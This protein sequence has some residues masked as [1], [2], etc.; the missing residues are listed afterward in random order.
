MARV[1]LRVGTTDRLL[2]GR[3]GWGVGL[4]RVVGAWGGVWMPGERVEQMEVMV[5]MT[6]M[7]VTMMEVAMVMMA[8]MAERAEMAQRCGGGVVQQPRRAGVGQGS[9]VCGVGA[10]VSTA[11]VEQLLGTPRAG[12]TGCRGV[13][14]GP[15]QVPG[16]RMVRVLEL[17][18]MRVSQ[19]GAVRV[20]G[21]QGVQLRVPG[22]LRLL[23]RVAGTVWGWGR[24]AACRAARGVC[25]WRRWEAVC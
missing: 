8:E 17:G 9:M 10:G 19:A 7:V 21:V 13:G 25:W 1:V 16:A 4:A 12:V 2:L 22:M 14:E 15:G 3:T 6:M 20:L 5:T 11:G 23:M 18:V 24:R